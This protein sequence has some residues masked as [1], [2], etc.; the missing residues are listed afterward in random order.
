MLTGDQN[1]VDLAYSVRWDIA[2]PQDFVFQIAKPTETV[3]ADRRKRD[4]R[5]RRRR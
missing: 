1:I 4:A 3:R 5:G 2:N